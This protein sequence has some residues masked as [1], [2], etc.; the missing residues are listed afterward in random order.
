MSVNY[1]RDWPTVS[2]VSN[3]NPVSFLEGANHQMERL[4]ISFPFD[5]L[6]CSRRRLQ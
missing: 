1:F 6:F 5:H 2:A 4:K 3:R